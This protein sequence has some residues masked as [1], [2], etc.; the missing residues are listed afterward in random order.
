[1][2]S[3]AYLEA[4]ERFLDPSDWSD[5]LDRVTRAADLAASVG[6]AELVKQAVNHADSMLDRHR[7][8]DSTFVT[9]FVMDLL[10]RFRRKYDPQTAKRYARY[11]ETAAYRAEA[12]GGAWDRARR[13]WR[14]A[15]D[16]HRLAGDTEAARRARLQIAET[17]VRNADAVMARPN[18]AAP[19][20]HAAAMLEQAMTVLRDIGGPGTDERRKEIYRRAIVHQQQSVGELIRHTDSVDLSH[21]GREAA[22]RVSGLPLSEALA[23]IGLLCVPPGVTGLR[24]Q[25]TRFRDRSPILSLFPVTRL[26]KSGAVVERPPA[27]T[28]P[29][30][31]ETAIRA[32]MFAN[33]AMLQ[34]MRGEAAVL[35]ALRQVHD[36][37]SIRL[38][39]FVQLSAASPIVPRGREVTFAK[40]LFA[41]YEFD[42][43]GAT[44]LLIPQVEQSVRLI[45]AATGCITS[46]FDRQGLQNE[47]DLNKTLRMPELEAVFGQDTV[48]DLRGLLVEHSGSNLRNLMAHGLMQ[49]EEFCTGTTVYLW[50]AILRLVLL[51]PGRSAN[52]PDGSEDWCI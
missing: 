39:A 36:D 9:A 41:G 5:W 26:S 44:H 18:Q 30:A 3:R 50:A 46:G 28:D 51:S 24:D 13:Y 35:P 17:Y 52:L 32:D 6:D 10:L 42:F 45:L 40:G 8:E 2:A 11:A 38:D 22:N 29:E 49:D 37:H 14:A 21:V 25:A 12:E 47:Y 1:M 48:F 43:I 16:W 15:G 31:R 7:G 34:R 20:L 19:N 27:G 4:S 23:G 33:A